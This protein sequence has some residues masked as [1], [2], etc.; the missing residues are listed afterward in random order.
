VQLKHENHCTHQ[1]GTHFVWCPKF[2]HQV[3]EGAVEVYLKRVIG[4]VCRTYKWSIEAIEIMPDHVHLFLQTSPHVALV[5]VAKIIKTITAIELFKMF[6]DLKRDKFWGSGMWSRG[7]FYGSV[8]QVSED[9][10]KNYIKSQK[11]TKS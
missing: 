5:D 6:P 11:T 7:T 9:I 10:I 1:V 8:G 3:L 4:E 2:R